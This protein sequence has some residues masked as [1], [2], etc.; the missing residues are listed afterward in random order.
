MH[1]SCASCGVCMCVGVYIMCVYVYVCMRVGVYIM[2]VYVYSVYVCMCVCVCVQVQMHDT[3][4][5][6]RKGLVGQT[7]FFP[8]DI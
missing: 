8:L 1:V 3:C 5:R 7:P 6:P 2:C 4:A